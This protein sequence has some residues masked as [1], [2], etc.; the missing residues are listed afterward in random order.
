VK[1]KNIYVAFL[2]VIIETFVCFRRIC[3][4]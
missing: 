3:A 1:F 4:A 2:G